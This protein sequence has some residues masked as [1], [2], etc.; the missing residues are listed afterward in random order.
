MVQVYNL[1]TRKKFISMEEKD[2]KGGTSIFFKFWEYGVPPH[3]R[4]KV[5]VIPVP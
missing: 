1:R 2:G 5:E 3:R 4:K